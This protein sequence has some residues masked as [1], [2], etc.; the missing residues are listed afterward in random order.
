MSN[1]IFNTTFF[2]AHISQILNI[3]NGLNRDC[4]REV[5]R[6]Y[7]GK[8]L[9]YLIANIYDSGS[10]C[11]GVHTH[12]MESK[13]IQAH[14]QSVLITRNEPKLKLTAMSPAVRRMHACQTVCKC[15]GMLM[16]EIIL[17]LC[18]RNNQKYLLFMRNKQ[19]R[20]EKLN[21][22]TDIPKI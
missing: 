19:Q 3:K 9:A 14:K 15:M 1:E 18:R 8:Y 16:L 10:R 11:R 2:K 13:Q 21:A 4:M 7:S 5:V 6:M 22:Y 17:I 20:Q 12:R